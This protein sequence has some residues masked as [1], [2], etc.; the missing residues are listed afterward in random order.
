MLMQPLLCPLYQLK[1]G[2]GTF[3]TGKFGLAFLL[4]HPT[5]GITAI[6]I[7]GHVQPFLL[8]QGKGV[9]NGE[10]LTNVICTVHRAEMKHLLEA[11]QVNAPI[12]HH[13]RIAATGRIHGQ[14]S[15]PLSAM[16][17]NARQP[18]GA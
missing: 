6:T 3:V 1:Q 13:A 7:H 10:K 4:L 2:L 14:G 15:P 9:D 18:T 8:E 16:A 12:L 5:D 17:G 11:G